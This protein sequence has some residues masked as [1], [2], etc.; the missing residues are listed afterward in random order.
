MKTTNYIS[1]KCNNQST[2]NM[3]KATLRHTIIKLLKTHEKEKLLKATRERRLI[4][5]RGT[6]IKNDSSYFS[7]ETMQVKSGATFLKD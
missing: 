4:M 5:Y 1:K 2:R 3:K 6:K 7:L